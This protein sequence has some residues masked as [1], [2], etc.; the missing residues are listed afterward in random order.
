MKPLHTDARTNAVST[1]TMRSDV[2]VCPRGHQTSVL[3]PIWV[4][5]DHARVRQR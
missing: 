4:P 5:G 1:K 3:D 2:C